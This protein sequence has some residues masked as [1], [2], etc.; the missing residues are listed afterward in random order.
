MPDILWLG[1]GVALGVILSEWANRMD[2]PPETAEGEEPGSRW[3]GV[4]V[5]DGEPTVRCVMQPD[6]ERWPGHLRN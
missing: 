3:R 2:A 4:L 5:V 1:L 6:P